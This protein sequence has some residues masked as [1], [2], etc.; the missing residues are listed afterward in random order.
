MLLNRLDRN[1]FAETAIAGRIGGGLLARARGTAAPY[2]P[3][4][5]CRDVQMS[6]VAKRLFSRRMQFLKRQTDQIVVQIWLRF[7]MQSCTKQILEF[8]LR[9]PKSALRPPIV[10]VSSVNYQQNDSSS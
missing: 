7:G 10:S 1:R 8:K 5:V 2:P 6:T 9:G 4:T 3:R